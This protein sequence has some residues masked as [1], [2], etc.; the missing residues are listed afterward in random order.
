MEIIRGLVLSQHLYTLAGSEYAHFCTAC[1][2][3]P[4]CSAGGKRW[5]S[6]ISSDEFS[7]LPIPYPVSCSPEADRLHIIKEAHGKQKNMVLAG[8]FI[9]H[10]HTGRFFV[11]GC[12]WYQGHHPAPFVGDDLGNSV[13]VPRSVVVFNI[14]VGG[15]LFKDK[16]T[17][18]WRATRP[19]HLIGWT[20]VSVNNDEP[21]VNGEIE[22]LVEGNS[23][24]RE[25]RMVKVN[26]NAIPVSII[27]RIYP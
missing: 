14:Q 18:E 5:S 20:I 11:A 9:L 1:P 7:G 16:V 22:L 2:P 24:K 12:F 26:S 27:G 17:S 13:G 10:L 6:P 8:S 4:E 25:R 23:G 21:D 19:E 3:Y 15:R